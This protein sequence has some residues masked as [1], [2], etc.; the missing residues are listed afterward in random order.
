MVSRVNCKKQMKMRVQGHMDV[1]FLKIIE[2]LRKRHCYTLNS[3]SLDMWAYYKAVLPSTYV[4][5][6]KQISSEAPS[7]WQGK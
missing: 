2:N 5:G 4:L 6:L 3:F 7:E 1:E